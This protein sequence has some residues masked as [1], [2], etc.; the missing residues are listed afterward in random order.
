MPLFYYRAKT[1]TA[2]TVDGQ[3]MADQR[4]QAIERIHQLGLIPVTVEL[5]DR[6]HQRIQKGRVGR[7][8][9]LLFTREVAS[10]LKGGVTILQAL[11]VTA[12]QI[13]S[14]YFRSVVQDIRLNVQGGTSF[15]ACLAG[16]PAIFSP[17]YV[18]MVQAGEEAGR[19][20]ECIESVAGH[21]KHQMALRAK[22]RSAMVYPLFMLVFGIGTVVFILTSV[23]PRIMGIFAD[24]GQ[25]LP[26][27]TVAVMGV[28]RFLVSYWA[29]ILLVVFVTVF[30]VKRWAATPS[31]RRSIT[32]WVMRTPVI[33]AFTLHVEIVYFCQALALLIRS[34]VPIVK[35]VALAAS[36]VSNVLLHEQLMQCH[37]DLVAGRS[38]GL[39][40]KGQTLIP[41]MVSSLLSVGET[42]GLLVQ[43]L[44]S[45]AENYS[46]EI[47][48][49][50]KVL[51]SLIEP[52]MIVLVGGMIAVIVIAMLLPI[53]Q[54]DIM[55]G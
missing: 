5:Y 46:E 33:G 7:R 41:D 44:E 17:L 15:S 27:L 49:R 20:V 38:L 10:L 54:M 2:D 18:S 32:G 19:L 39:A 50:M 53:F 14:A 22:V 43:A 25:A 36:V 8:D 3:I 6:T 51:S 45:V 35:S 11:D 12:R 21:L 9:I 40:L 13:R 42:S 26:A 52:I 30:A 31:G 16:F 34:G 24:S 28:S 37:D 1:A 23:M 48:D 47:D 4:E 55:A 29:V